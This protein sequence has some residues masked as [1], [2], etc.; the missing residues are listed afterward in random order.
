MDVDKGQPQVS[1]SS[2]PLYFGLLW[3]NEL[4]LLRP[5]L[6]AILTN[7]EEIIGIAYHQHETHFGEGRRISGADA[8]GALAQSMFGTLNA[9]L[10]EGMPQYA[11]RIIGVGELLAEREV[12]LREVIV[13]LHFY[14]EAAFKLLPRLASNNLEIYR[15]FD[16]LAHIRMALLAEGYLRGGSGST[17]ARSNDELKSDAPQS[18]ETS[19]R[20]SFS[21]TRGVRSAAQTPPPLGCSAPPIR[22][23]CSWMKLPR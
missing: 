12:P 1:S 19:S 8:F 17:G 9:L 21:V 11:M 5:L 7:R 2:G 22:A 13:G 18:P 20:A 15:L 16:K 14:E 23:R 6:R 10:E 4:E 3:D